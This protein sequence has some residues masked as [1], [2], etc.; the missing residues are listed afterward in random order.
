[1]E[2]KN[3]QETNCLHLCMIYLHT[4]V[5]YKG[6]YPS[7]Q[8]NGWRSLKISHQRLPHPRQ[9]QIPNTLLKILTRVRIEKRRKHSRSV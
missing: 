2:C 7:N 5:F 1:M 3:V 9:D 6:L 8:F 4:V